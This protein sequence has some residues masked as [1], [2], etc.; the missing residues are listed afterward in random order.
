MVA[1]ENTAK[2][3]AKYSHNES[4]G[5][6]YGMTVVGMQDKMPGFENVVRLCVYFPIH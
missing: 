1:R 3:N 6:N 2:D 5:Y 4:A